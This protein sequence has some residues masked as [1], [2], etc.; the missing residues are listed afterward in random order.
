ML[1]VFLPEIEQYNLKNLK[2]F[3][4]IISA[5]K[6][7]FWFWTPLFC[8]LL[9]PVNAEY[10][11]EY[12]IRGG[13]T[14]NLALFTTWPSHQEDP[15]INLCLIGDPVM[16]DSFANLNG[17]LI[18]TKY[19]QVHY[20]T[21]LNNLSECRIL[22]IGE[23]NKN[24]LLLLLQDIQTLPIL[25]IGEDDTF[26]QNGGMVALKNVNGS[27]AMIVNLSAVKKASLNISARVL[28]LATVIK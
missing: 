20:L 1:L 24:K 12:S 18:G 11:Q 26:V 3:I 21:R 19:L 5:K 15:L 23:I 14:A 2:Y 4:K 25:T 17:K 10:Y 16:E 8:S 7:L 9:T 27:I 6:I 28:K 13:F 22:Y